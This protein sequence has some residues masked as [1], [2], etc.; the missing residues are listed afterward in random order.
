[1]ALAVGTRPDG[2]PDTVLDLLGELAERVYVSVEYGLQS[3]HD[4][5]LDWMNRQH[6]HE[7]TVDAILRSRGRGFEIGAHVIL[8]LPGESHDQM[9][10][11]A[12]ELARLRVDSVKIHNLYA[13]KHTALADQVRR[14]AVRLMSQREYV[15]TL[16]DF[17]ELL[18]PHVIIQRISGDAPAVHLVGPDWCLDKQAVRAAG[19]ETMARRATWHGRLA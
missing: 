2:V 6:G 5:S 1:M 19:N 16:V 13:V 15:E 11:T 14:G 9:M 18:P 12:R 4:R 3:M 17:L 10:A 7:S 8:G